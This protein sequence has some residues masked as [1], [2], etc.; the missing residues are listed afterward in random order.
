MTESRM[1]WKDLRSRRIKRSLDQEL[2]LEIILRDNG[3][4]WC[5]YG[6]HM[7]NGN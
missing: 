7:Y 3:S 1:V 5:T 4:S 2:G 6:A